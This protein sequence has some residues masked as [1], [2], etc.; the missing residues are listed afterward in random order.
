MA[1]EKKK[2]K[3]KNK[4]HPERSIGK[5]LK[6]YSKIKRFSFFNSTERR[7]NKEIGEYEQEKIII[8]THEYDYL[9]LY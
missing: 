6:G 7:I 3:V 1:S 9:V 4:L 8:D 5:T 2:R